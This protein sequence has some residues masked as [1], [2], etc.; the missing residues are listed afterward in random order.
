MQKKS[1]FVPSDTRVVNSLQENDLFLIQ[2]TFFLLRIWCRL[3]LHTRR[4]V[5]DARAFTDQTQERGGARWDKKAFLRTKCPLETLSLV[6]P[7]SVSKTSKKHVK[8]PYFERSKCPTRV[9]EKL[10]KVLPG[11]SGKS[12]SYQ[13]FLLP[14]FQNPKNYTVANPGPLSLERAESTHSRLVKLFFAERAKGQDLLS[15]YSRGV[16]KCR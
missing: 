16:K 6:D 14:G 8:N 1:D 12:R 7:L 4:V 3:I 5:P 11:F 15:V 13:G 10:Q 2:F 9:F